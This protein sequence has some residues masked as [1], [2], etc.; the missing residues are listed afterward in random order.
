MTDEER[1]SL[2][3]IH[4]ALLSVPVGSSSDA[5]PLIEEI[6]VI[7]KAYN[8][9]G[10][11]VRSLLYLILTGAGVAASFDKIKEWTVGS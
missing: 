4:D 7:V 6:R 2:K 8:R 11:I 1:K 10:W 9:S 3:D 5:K